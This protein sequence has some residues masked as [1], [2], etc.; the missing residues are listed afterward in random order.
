MNPGNAA[1]PA[2]SL[3]NAK[4][5]DALYEMGVACVTISKTK[6]NSERKLDFSF[7]MQ[8][9]TG[10]EKKT[11]EYIMN[12]IRFSVSEKVVLSHYSEYFTDAYSQYGTEIS[13]HFNLENGTYYVT[14]KYTKSLST[15]LLN[16]LLYSQV[17]SLFHGH[18]VTHFIV[19]FEFNGRS[20]EEYI[21]TRGV[22]SCLGIDRDLFAEKIEH[23]PAK[24]AIAKLA[25]HAIKELR[26]KHWGDELTGAIRIDPINKEVEIT[27]YQTKSL[28]TKEDLGAVYHVQL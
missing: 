21:I 20:W 27:C 23:A 11:P 10:E 15:N 16:P 25:S 24:E 17:T 4:L 26:E 3:F 18:D 9:N 7:V 14:D 8:P 6:E 5:L 28:Y 13:L 19:D 22:H 12:F 2:Y 1:S